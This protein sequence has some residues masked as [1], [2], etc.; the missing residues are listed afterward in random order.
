MVGLIGS[1]LDEETR[2]DAEGR[3]DRIPMRPDHGHLMGDEVGKEAVKPGYSYAGRLK[4]LAELRGV[5][6]ALDAMRNRT[7][8]KPTSDR[9]LSPHQLN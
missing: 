6:H 4:G 8:V 2:R 9:K 3:T 1:L 5:I 7:G